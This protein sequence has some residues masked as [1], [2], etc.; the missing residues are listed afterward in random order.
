L[1]IARHPG[2]TQKEI[3]RRLNLRDSGQ[4]R[5]TAALTKYGDRGR[6]AWDVVDMHENPEDRREK[7]LRL[8][9]KGDLLLTS[10]RRHVHSFRK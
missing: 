5:T 2:I 9:R 8:N 10:L 4:S 1:L 7:L 6:H 3:L